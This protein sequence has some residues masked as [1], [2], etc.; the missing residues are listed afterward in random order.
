MS[1]EEKKFFSNYKE[2]I[3][4]YGSSEEE[5]MEDL[6]LTKDLDPPKDIFAE[7]RVVVDCG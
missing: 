6:D 7:V 4:N 2:I 5:L 1:E 3:R